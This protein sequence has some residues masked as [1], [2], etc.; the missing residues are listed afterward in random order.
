ML[1]FRIS[2]TVFCV[3]FFLFSGNTYSIAKQKPKWLRIITDEN[4]IANYLDVASLDSSKPQKFYTSARI[5]PRAAVN[6]RE[7][8]LRR[9]YHGERCPCSYDFAINESHCGGRASGKTT[10]FTPKGAAS[11]LISN[12]VNCKTKVRSILNIDIYD[13]NNKQI[14]TYSAETLTGGAYPVA[15]KVSDRAELSVIKAVCK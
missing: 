11:L 14:T 13:K 5:F 3:W 9:P 7:M 4:Q 6:N 10:C 8:P 1:E 15:V 2:L 12:S